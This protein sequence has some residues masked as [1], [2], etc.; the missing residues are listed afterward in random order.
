MFRIRSNFDIHVWFDSNINKEWQNLIPQDK[1][2]SP[3]DL[4]E[5]I[6]SLTPWFCE[7]DK[8]T[9]HKTASSKL[10]DIVCNKLSI[11]KSLEYDVLFH[12]ITKLLHKDKQLFDLIGL[13]GSIPPKNIHRMQISP[14]WC[15]DFYSADLVL[16]VLNDCMIKILPEHHLLDLGCSSGSLTRIFNWLYPKTIFHG[17][18]PVQDS[19][20]W[21]L[22]N[23]RGIN[24]FRCQQEPPLELPDSSIDGIIA[25]SIWSHHS[26]HASKIWFSEMKRILKTGGWFL[27]TVHGMRSLY[28]YL[29][30]INKPIE[31]WISVY[32]GLLQNNSVFEEIWITQDDVG[33]SSK[34][35]GNFYVRP[36][37]IIGELVNDFEILLFKRGINQSNQDVYLC[38]KL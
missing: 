23:L 9:R 16:D 3:Y 17:C 26:E 6:S 30:N 25:L 32:E 12:H 10:I 7:I 22:S 21:A 33:N 2:T 11:K 15:G 38:R 31:R 1:F 36:E 24:F 4:S 35:W 20:D 29:S 37:W 5:F 27:F 8:F 18:D 28:Y 34:D 19:I 13:P 14:Y